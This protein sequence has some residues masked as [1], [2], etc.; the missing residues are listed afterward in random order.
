M[1]TI[2]IIDYGS[3]NFGSVWNAVSKLNVKMIRV[4]Q[5]SELK[6][7]SG[8]I[9]PGVGAF[10]ASMKKLHD[11]EIVESLTNEVLVEKKPFL[12]IC[13]GMQ[14]LA[15]KG[16][17]HGEHAGL[18]WIDGEVRRLLENNLPLPHVGWNTI[19]SGIDTSPLTK[20]IDG[21]ATFYFVHSFRLETSDSNIITLRTKYSEEFIS[22]VSKDNIHGVQFHPEKSQFYGLKLIENFVEF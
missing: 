15:K 4:T 5:S 22:A 7:C 13:V 9:L 1:K 10:G 21:D 16:F 11:M 20:G 8:I 19:T 6:D 18:G 3:G 2:G 14:I 12:G 17:E